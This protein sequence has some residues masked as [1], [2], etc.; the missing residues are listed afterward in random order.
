MGLKVEI[1]TILITIKRRV[2]YFGCVKTTKLVTSHL[3]TCPNMFLIKSKGLFF[4]VLGFDFV[5][6]KKINQYTN[7]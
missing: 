4:L 5:L 1:H 7:R 2:V 3:I 6:I